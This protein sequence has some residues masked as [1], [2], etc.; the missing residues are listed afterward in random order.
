M[1]APE[2]K[3][4]LVLHEDDLTLGRLQETLLSLGYPATPCRTVQDALSLAADRDFDLAL[5]SL[6]AYGPAP[7]SF[8]LP[9]RHHRPGLPVIVMAP[10]WG[11]E[12]AL[13]ALDQGADD[14]ITLPPHPAE[15]RLR[16]E[17]I[18]AARQLG[19]R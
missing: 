8:A 3:Q 10:A 5:L 14:Y 18:L 17:R 7:H 19:I 11:L 12:A 15:M 1:F 9:L 13:A 4:I 6:G 2:N 16:M